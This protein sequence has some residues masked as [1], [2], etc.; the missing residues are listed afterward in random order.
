[1]RRYRKNRSADVYEIDDALLTASEKEAARLA[2][3]FDRRWLVATWVIM[4]CLSAALLGRIFYLTV[5]RGQYYSFVASGNSVRETPIL[6]PRGMMYDMHGE[7]LVDNIASRNLV[8]TPEALPHADGD[9][10]LAARLAAVIAMS[11]DEIRETLI[12]ARTSMEHSVLAQNISHEHTLAI[13]ARAEQFPGIRIQQ[14]AM[15]TY[16]DGEVFSH[17]IGYEG[18][19]KKEERDLHPDY[20]LTDRIGKTGLEMRYERDVH[21]VHGAQ[22]VLVDSRG[23]LVKDLG[24]IAPVAGRDLHL[25]IDAGLQRVL[26]E[27]LQRELHRAKTRRAAAVAIDPR[28][29]AVRA[30]VSLPSYD[31]NAFATG[32]DSAT[33]TALVNDADRPLFNRAIGGAYAPGSTIKPLMAL[34]ALAERI[35]TP[36]RKIESRGGLQIG[37]FFFGDWRVHGFTDMRRAIAVSSDVY[38]YTIGGGYGD[39]AG[40]GIDRMKSY[41]TK[42]GYGHKTGIDLPGEVSGF[43]PDATWKK[44][45]IGERWYI[46]NTYHASIGQGYV[47]ATPLQVAHTTTFIANGGTL[48]QPHIVAWTHDTVTGDRTETP[49]TIIDDHL[50]TPEEL[51]VAQE[52]MRE[53]VMGGTATMLKHLPVAV[54]GKTGTAQF[55]GS[56]NVHSW[57]VAYAPY[58]A[59]HLVLVV[60]VEGQTGELSSTTVPV[61]HDVLQWY[62]GGRGAVSDSAADG[63]SPEEVSPARVITH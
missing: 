5:V 37:S 38:F 3:Q 15:R 42:F 13:K 7:R 53:T 35:I 23:D 61:A 43:Y 51:R 32:V 60:M 11:E 2:F 59:P 34:A 63:T 45:V 1:M 4:M 19:I 57:F 39:I 25:T 48:Y 6:A 31:N 41:M 36:D 30:L 58:D 22:R 62:F 16:T 52:G 50:A 10:A 14:D 9:A 27:R 24:S 33:Y 44:D 55:G 18:L 20:L 29:G 12:R 46:G 40:L 8:I 54:A 47:T 21:G 28:N 26:H 17:I 49:I 56:K